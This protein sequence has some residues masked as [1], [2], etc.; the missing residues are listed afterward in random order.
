MRKVM[1]YTSVNMLHL[2]VGNYS[3]IM[4]VRELIQEMGRVP[5]SQITTQYKISPI[6][7]SDKQT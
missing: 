2:V 5:Q 4:M 1:E 7:Q 3:G 6:D